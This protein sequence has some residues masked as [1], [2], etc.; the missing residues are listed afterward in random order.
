MATFFVVSRN[1]AEN[2]TAVPTQVAAIRAGVSRPPRSR[3]TVATAPASAAAALTARNTRCGVVG[4][5]NG[6]PP[7]V[8]QSTCWTANVVVPATRTPASSRCRPEVPPARWWGEPPWA[9]T[10]QRSRAWSTNP[11]SSRAAC[12]AK[13]TYTTT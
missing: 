12:A 4:A 5:V 9:T 7:T 13:P 10:G 11:V 2:G 3:P 8:A 6:P 1:A